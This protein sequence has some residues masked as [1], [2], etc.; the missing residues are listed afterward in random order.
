[1]SRL[2][3][4]FILPKVDDMEELNSSAVPQPHLLCPF[5]RSRR[6]RKVL[7]CDGNCSSYVR[8]SFC[9]TVLKMTVGRSAQCL[10]DL[11]TFSSARNDGSIKKYKTSKYWMAITKCLW[12]PW[13]WRSSVK[14]VVE[15]LHWL[16]VPLFCLSAC[17]THCGEKPH[18]L[19]TSK[20]G[21]QC[22]CLKPARF[23]FWETK[24]LGATWTPCFFCDQ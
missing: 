4:L 3:P 23:I 1:M 18:K 5:L 10:A 8:I 20:K 13:R 2:I 19:R 22:V 15:G 21:S 12:S 16:T 7:S 24:G 9:A 14:V 6:K 11:L 17:K